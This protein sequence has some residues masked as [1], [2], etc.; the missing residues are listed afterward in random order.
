MACDKNAMP[1]VIPSRLLKDVVVI[2][3]AGVMSFEY[4]DIRV[5]SE[6]IGALVKASVDELKPRVDYNG[7]FAAKICVV[8]TL[9]GDME[10]S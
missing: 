2:N 10:V 4:D 7:A 1:E 6:S 3:R 8:V 9:L 5:N